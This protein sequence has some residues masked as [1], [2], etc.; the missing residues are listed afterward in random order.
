M[1]SRATTTLPGPT[2]PRAHGS[3]AMPWPPG[4]TAFPPPAAPCVRGNASLLSK[5]PFA[6]STAPHMSAGGR[7]RAA[8][9]HPAH[10]AAMARP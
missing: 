4:K 3:V 2:A 6:A 9:A 7:L 8:I 10:P 1:H 5:Y